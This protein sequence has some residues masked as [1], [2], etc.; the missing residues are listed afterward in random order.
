MKAFV[1]LRILVGTTLRDGA[2]TVCALG[3]GGKVQ[4]KER[5]N[6]Q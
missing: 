2:Q 3:G 5:T 6:E 4:E 1:A